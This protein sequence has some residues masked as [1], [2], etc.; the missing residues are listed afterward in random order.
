MPPPSI[1]GELGPS[2]SSCRPLSATVP[3]E[4][5]VGGPRAL[6]AMAPGMA[7]SST[8]SPSS[9]KP[10]RPYSEVEQMLALLDQRVTQMAHSEGA[11]LRMVGDQVQRLMEGLQAMRVAR[12]VQDE[13][14]L[15]EIRMLESNVMLDLRKAAEGRKEME[16]RAGE[17][18]T[19]CL[20]EHRSWVQRTLDDEA[21]T[22]ADYAREIQ[23]EVNRLTAI[24]EEQ[25]VAR[26]EVGEHCAGLIEA[27]LKKVQCDVVAEQK[28]RFEAECTVQQMVERLGAKM[29]AEI[30]RERSQREAV[31]G[32]LLTL[33]E[34]ACGRIEATFDFA[35]RTHQVM[36]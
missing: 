31:Q 5:L 20:A 34:D 24:L 14:R 1:R 17:L 16:V 22:H 36:I 8:S 10:R 9:A 19:H 7:C 35:T 32:K 4:P 29:K 2:S 21:K 25:R 27:E 3:T 30:D 12:E 6:E 26:V 18:S 28:L 13:R 11:R 23:G 33:L 15:K